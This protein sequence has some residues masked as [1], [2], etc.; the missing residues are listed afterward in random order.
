MVE[1]KAL[2]LKKFISTIL[3]YE[4]KLEENQREQ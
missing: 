1:E 4:I 2:S 3:A